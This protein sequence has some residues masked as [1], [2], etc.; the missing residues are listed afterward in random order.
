M[1][2]NLRSS[3]AQAMAAWQAEIVSRVTFGD[4]N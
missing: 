4:E 1:D 2:A 3:S